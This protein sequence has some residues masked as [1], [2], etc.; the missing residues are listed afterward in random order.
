M[1]LS[2]VAGLAVSWG[3]LSKVLFRCETHCCF[4][5]A[6]EQWMRGVGAMVVG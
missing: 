1:C 5:V 2:A 3:K 4:L 6:L